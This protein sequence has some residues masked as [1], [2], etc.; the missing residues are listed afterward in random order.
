MSFAANHAVP[1]P[2]YVTVAEGPSHERSFVTEATFV[3]HRVTV[4][5]AVK[6]VSRT[7]AAEALVTALFASPRES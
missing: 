4:S 3:G 6:S 1:V 7:S 5:A 2:T